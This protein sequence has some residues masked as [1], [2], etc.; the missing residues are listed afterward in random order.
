[1]AHMRQP[2]PITARV[3]VV[4]PI[5]DAGA[6]LDECL[7]SISRQTL[8][9]YEVVVVDDGSSDKGPDIAQAHAR[10]DARLRLIE[11]SLAGL[12][13]ALNT[14]IDQSSAALIAR[15]DADDIMHP[16]RLARQ[17]E[18]LDRHPRIDVV[19]SRV[20]A[21]P[22]EALGKGMTEY[23]RWQNRCVSSCDMAEEIFVESPLTHPSVMFRRQSVFEA[24]GYKSGDFPEDYELW[25]RMNLRGCRFAKLPETL[26][27]WRQSSTSLS[28]ID[29]RYAREA[30]DRLRAHYLCRRLKA[31]GQRPIVVW[32]AGRRTRGRCRHLQQR[33]VTVAAWIDIDPRKIGQTVGG[34]KVH[35]PGWL[36]TESGQRPFVLVYVA[37]HGAR[38][39][40]GEEL[41][42]FD[43]RR[44]E[45]YL[46]VG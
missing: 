22:A 7:R 13:G 10:R 27:E 45:D 35:P 16:E 36:E 12:V 4:L 30:F 31:I 42:R 14:G 40:I 3:S 43:Y 2:L 28:R 32:G 38:D 21:F 34:A 8:S 19:G 25:L 44:G 39:L 11:S 15:M 1:M 18:F 26:L 29:P 23:L 5:R 41:H 9:G 33:G 17:V 37:S 20:H 46:M 6:T 24:G